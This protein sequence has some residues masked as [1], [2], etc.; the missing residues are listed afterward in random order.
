MMRTSSLSPFQRQFLLGIPGGFL[1]CLPTSAPL[2]FEVMVVTGSQET[3][4]ELNNGVEFL[5]NIHRVMIFIAIVTWINHEIV[6]IWMFPKIV[7]I[8]PK[9]SI[10]RGVFHYFHHPFWGKT[11]YFRKHPSKSRS[12]VV[13]CR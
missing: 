6:M 5:D 1:R 4:T 13:D 7:G 3:L 8:P 10:L 12:L 2:C 11:F 9:S